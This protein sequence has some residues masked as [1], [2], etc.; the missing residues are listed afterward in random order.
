[1]ILAAAALA[2]RLL[3]PDPVPIATPSTAQRQRSVGQPTTRPDYFLTF[4][5]RSPHNRMVW[6][7]LLVLPVQ[8]RGLLLALQIYEVGN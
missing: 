6:T 3:G 7:T 5:S 4:T 2:R 8:G 1:M